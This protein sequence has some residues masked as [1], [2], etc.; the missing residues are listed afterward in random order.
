MAGKK[1]EKFTKGFRKRMERKKKEKRRRTFKN[2]IIM[3]CY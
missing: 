3:C 2:S 1:Y